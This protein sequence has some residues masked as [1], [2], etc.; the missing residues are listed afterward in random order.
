MHNTALTHL[1][2]NSSLAV[3]TSNPAP[4]D[5]QGT[6]ARLFIYPVKSCAGVELTEAI[7]TE[8]GLDLDRSWMVVEDGG[9][10]VTQREQPRMALIRP[11]V[12]GDDIVLRAH[13]MLALHLRIDVVEAVTQARIWDDVVTCYDMG[14][15]AA[16]WFSDF[17]APQRPPGAPPRPFRLVRF[18]PEHQRL[19]SRKWTGDIEAQNQFSDGFPM[20]VTSTASLDGL[21]RRLQAN[22]LGPVTMERFR[23]NIVLTGIDEHD[24]D[25][26]NTIH[27]TT[28]DGAVLLR[29]VKP[30]VRC[31]IP[32][33]DPQTASSSTVVGDMLQTYRVDPRVGGV[34]FGMNAITID[35][36]DRVLRVGQPFGGHLQFD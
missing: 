4:F 16:Q 25:R 15:V 5:V 2:P 36:M 12:R 7:L 22:G 11:Q 13:G 3:T 10:F 20:L 17:L 23:P 21:N 18:D 33:I 1:H 19:A 14:D 31:P 35:G 27:V 28:P 6:I 34:T 29:P 30:C 26:I 32:N 8:T 9:M 24:E